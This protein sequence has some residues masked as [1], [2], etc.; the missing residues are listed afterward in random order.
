MEIYKFLSEILTN[1]NVREYVIKLMGTFLS[2]STKN[3]KFHV[4]I[5]SSLKDGSL[6]YGEFILSGESK[7]EFLISTY[8]CHPSLANDNLSGLVL[9]IFLLRALKQKK[10]K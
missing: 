5:D 1:K 9:W 2:G 7:K 3:E 6:T 10:L 4:R 8:C